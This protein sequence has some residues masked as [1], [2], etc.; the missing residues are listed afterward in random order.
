MGVLASAPLLAVASSR[1]PPSASSTALPMTRP[2]SPWK[3][4]A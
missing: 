1:N 4:S 2:M 3:A